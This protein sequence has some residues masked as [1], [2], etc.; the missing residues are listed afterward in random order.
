MSMYVH[1]VCVC[2]CVWCVC[3]C[4][5]VL[6]WSWG[7]C[8]AR[9]PPHH[10]PENQIR[11]KGIAPMHAA[12]VLPPARGAGDT[13]V[14]ACT[15]RTWNSRL[16]AASRRNAYTVSLM[17]SVRMTSFAC[18]CSTP[19]ACLR[20]GRRAVAALLLP[21]WPWEHPEAGGQG[22]T[23]A[24]ELPDRPLSNPSPD[25]AFACAASRHSPGLQPH[26]TRPRRA[27]PVPHAPVR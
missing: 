5:C 1:C 22:A 24:W 13:R 3:V 15:G 12:G 4:A 18:R 6:G 10:L 21:S 26:S 27:L 14:C 25:A 16:R 20:A 8:D 23:V 9:A 19:C 11:R 17:P 7:P 2:M